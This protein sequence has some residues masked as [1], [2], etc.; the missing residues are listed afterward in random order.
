MDSLPKESSLNKL[1][2]ELCDREL[3]D[4]GA[5]GCAEMERQHRS[6]SGFSDNAPPPPP[7]SKRD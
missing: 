4:V 5:A 3:A 6:L 2:R 1:E 7:P